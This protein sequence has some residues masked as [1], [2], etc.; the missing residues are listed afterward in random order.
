MLFKKGC[1]SNTLNVIRSSISFFCSLLLSVGDNPVIV[2]LFKFFHRSRPVRPKYFTF[3]P[4]GPVI[5][6]LSQ[7]HPAS[8]LSL[9][10]LTLKTLALIALSSS[11]RGQTLH[12][13]NIDR[14]Q[15]ENDGISFVVHDILKTTKRRNMKPRV[16][17]CIVTDDPSLNV[18][19]YVLTYMN[20]TLAIRSSYCKRG[21]DKP[22]KL[23]LSWKTKAPVA[24][25]TLARWLKEVLS[26]AGIDTKQFSAH[27]FR[28]AGLS[29]AA[30][31]G[32]SAKDILAAG[33]WTNINTFNNFYNA[34]PSN[35]AVGRLILDAINE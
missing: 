14:T 10:Q 34:P 9:K 8:S 7:W 25:N 13:L 1:K 35:S 24:K 31:R 22:V 4:V 18:C 16:V 2:R 33:D 27:S 3:W 21:L 12:S 15:I 23:F 20:R 30:S 26:M 5:R 29:S 6:F 17:R 32:A 11:D 28:G 19:D